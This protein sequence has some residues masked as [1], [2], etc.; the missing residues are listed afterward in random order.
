MTKP[1]SAKELADRAPTAARMLADSIG[2]RKP[3]YADEVGAQL[4]TDVEAFLSRYVVFQGPE[5][6]LALALWVIATYCWQAFDAFAYIVITSATKRSGKTRLSEVMSFVCSNPRNFAAATAA[7]VFRIIK[8][9]APT[10]FMDEAEKQSSE[11]ADD[12]RTILNVG[13][14]KG[15]TVPRLS[16]R[17]VIEWPTYCPKVFVLIG[18]VRDTLRD[19][20]IVVQLVRGRPAMRFLY[21]VAKNEGQI[22]RERIASYM[23]LARPK[24]ADAYLKHQ[25]LSFLTDRD[26]EIWT[27]IFTLAS[28]LVPER[29]EELTRTAVDL[30]AE[31]TAPAQ[32][33]NE[34]E[35]SE[36]DR[37]ATDAEYAERLL[38][39]LL[40][41]C[42]HHKY[43]YTKDALEK[44]HAAPEMPWRRFRGKGL[45]YM[46]LP[47]L[48]RRFDVR[49]DHI[50][51][52]G[53]KR[54]DVARGYYRA[55]LLKA[56]RK[57]LG[58]G[59]VA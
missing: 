22:I 55:D 18:D 16:D 30:A 34:L 49:P 17:G 5:Y 44:L 21:E 47:N 25:G 33:H 27:P 2:R 29:L 46:D 14:R 52:E 7:N 42:G 40:L 57:Y 4:V 50:R 53:G 31:K 11:T 32:K 36:A 20:S 28:V 15:Q 23:E 12:M 26:E 35:M 6:S 8:D 45:T 39:D 10:I 13:Y 1:I 56:A 43:I 37:K 54:G 59:A 41:V 51:K 24:V 9:E 3:K 38:R 19:R 58:E 48:L